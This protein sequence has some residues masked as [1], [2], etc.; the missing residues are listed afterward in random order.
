MRFKFYPAAGG[1]ATFFS[2]TDISAITIGPKH[3]GMRALP[4]GGSENVPMDQA[5][6]RA[7]MT[8]ARRTG[9]R[10]AA[11]TAATKAGYNTFSCV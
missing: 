11:T 5:C 1:R 6:A 3:T 4:L 10:V 7:K 9:D 8:E 2:I